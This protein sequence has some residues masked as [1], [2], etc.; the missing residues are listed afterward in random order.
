MPWN[1]SGTYS[2]PA[3]GNSLSPT[4]TAGTTIVAADFNELTNDLQT[5]MT[6]CITGDGI[7]HVVTADLPM[8]TKKHTGVGDA[9]ALDQYA[10]ANQVVDNTL[11]YCATPSAV[12]TDDYVVSLP[13][14]PVA[15]V[16]GNRFQFIPE[17]A[18]TGACTVDFN[19]ISSVTP[20]SI[21][22]ANGDDP[23]DGA[24]QADV[25]CDV[26]YDGTSFILMNP[27]EPYLDTT[28]GTMVAS[29]ALIADASKNFDF[30]SGT[31]SN[32]SFDTTAVGVT[33]SAGDNSVSLATTAYADT[34]GIVWSGANLDTT[35]TSELGEITT[36]PANANQ[37]V[38]S[39]VGVSLNGAGTIFVELGDFSY[40]YDI[41]LDAAVYSTTQNTA[42]EKHILSLPDATGDLLFGTV[43]FTRIAGTNS[44]SISGTT[45]TSTEDPYY[46]VG[47]FTATGTV[48][49]IRVSAITSTFDAGVAS[50]YW[51]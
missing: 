7:N 29:K 45:A 2:L 37:V 39:L 9:A 17:I 43:T 22:M 24:I 12:G 41:H 4:A 46:I 10:S 40:S 3:G 51:K 8:A 48:D 35:G 14:N 42:I 16:A 5:A 11:S 30:D 25:P 13:I 47:G 36:I 27:F 49:R 33:Q 38:L 1:G 20:K 23:I 21:K 34:A 44:W 26:M 50:V 19:G 15:Y 18:N 6:T 28:P 31:L 32:A